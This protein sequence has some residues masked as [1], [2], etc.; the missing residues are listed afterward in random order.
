MSNIPMTRPEEMLAIHKTSYFHSSTFVKLEDGRIL[1]AAGTTFTTSHDG[2]IT[3]SEPFSCTDTQGNRVGGSG[4]S[5]VNLSGKGIGLAAMRRDSG[6][7]FPEFTCTNWFF[8]K[9]IER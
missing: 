2:G 6:G 1:H 5:L 9:G 8:K 4:T 7:C 3:W